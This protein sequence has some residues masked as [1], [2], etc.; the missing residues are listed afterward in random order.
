MYFEGGEMGKIKKWFTTL[1][2]AFLVVWT[3]KEVEDDINLPEY[4]SSTKFLLAGC[5][6]VF[7]L[8]QIY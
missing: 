4:P 7:L 6:L 5:F 1:I 2:A 3:R 8:S